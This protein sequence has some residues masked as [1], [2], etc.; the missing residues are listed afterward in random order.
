[1]AGGDEVAQRGLEMRAR[2]KDVHGVADGGE[3]RDEVGRNHEVTDA[4]RGKGTL[5]NVPT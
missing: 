3:A 4:Q 5:L 1:M 2:R